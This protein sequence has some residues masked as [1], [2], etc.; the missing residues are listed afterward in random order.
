MLIDHFVLFTKYRRTFYYKGA[1]NKLLTI[2]YILLSG[3]I[4]A[5]NIFALYLSEY[6]HVVFGVIMWDNRINIL[7]EERL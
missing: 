7:F 3:N 5:V 2:R 1:K 6:Q 4:I